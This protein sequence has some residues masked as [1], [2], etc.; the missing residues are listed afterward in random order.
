MQRLSE[1]SSPKRGDTAGNDDIVCSTWQHVAGCNSG[2]VVATQPEHQGIY[3]FL[4]GAGDTKLGS[5][6]EP[7]A[8]PA[9]QAQIGKRLKAKFFKAIPAIK[10]L[11]DDVQAAV[12]AR[13]WLYG[14]DKRRLHVRSKH[15]A[16]NTLLQSAGAVLVKLA[17]VICNKEA[18]AR[19]GWVQGRDYTQILHVHDEAQF[20]CP[21]EHAEALGKL[22]VESIEMAGRHF[23]M[24]CPTTGEYKIGNN[25]AETH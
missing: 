1:R 9:R 11:I 5:I 8:S 25:W 10:C 14:I 20:Q 18:K 4:Y 24:R 22:F 3:A 23:A 19:F 2:A 13:P 6:V 16:L 17:T 15:A 21:V 12:S 7:Y